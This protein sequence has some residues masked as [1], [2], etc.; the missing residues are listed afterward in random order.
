MPKSKA[1][2]LR[3]L[4]TKRQIITAADAAQLGENIDPA[5]NLGLQFA[6]RVTIDC[7]P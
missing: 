3:N 6:E 4:A 5:S 1:D 2:K 7:K